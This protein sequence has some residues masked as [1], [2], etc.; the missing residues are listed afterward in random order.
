MKKIL[1][2]CLSLC[3]LILG[4]IN[5]FAQKFQ[6]KYI[7]ENDK[8]FLA[9]TSST[10]NNGWIEFRQGKDVEAI[11]PDGFFDRF[12][13]SLG[14]GEGYQMRSMKDKDETDFRQIRHQRFQ[15]FYKGVRVEGVEF[16]LHS[17]TN[18]LES[19]HGRVVENLT[20]DVA[21]A[22]TERQALEQALVDQKLSTDAF[23]GQELPKAEL[24]I[25]K[26]G[27][28]VIS[29]NFRLCYVFD[30]RTD[31]LPTRK[32]S[33]SEPQRVYVDAA[34][35]Q[36]VRHDPLLHNCFHI[37]THTGK[38]LPLVT[39][40]TSQEHVST[41]GKAPL[42]ASN[43]VPRWARYQQISNTFETEPG[44]G[45]YRLSHQNGALVT[46]R[47]VNSNGQWAAN[48]DVLNGSTNWGAN[49]QNATTAHWLTQRVYQFY[50]QFA[51]DQ[52]GYNRQ[53]TY[54]SHS[55]RL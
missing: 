20:L 29:Q 1:I 50:Q 51:P 35:G 40:P 32:E 31:L 36:I 37:P 10:S 47:D 9:L 4:G 11:S 27:E 52:N 25:A 12:G 43:F 45:Q 24:L 54:S 34:S 33:Y 44:G 22:T 53:G 42:V 19:A 8:A 14:L 39:Q 6:P 18:R 28:E 26:I 13:K 15:L 17:R 3:Y 21:K 49:A 30:I 38:T 7:R 16:S 55:S 2:L 46:R 41:L 5:S 48:P 23:K